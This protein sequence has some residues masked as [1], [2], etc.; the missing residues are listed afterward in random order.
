MLKYSRAESVGLKMSGS[1]E[2]SMNGMFG[3]SMTGIRC[4]FPFVVLNGV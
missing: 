4:P 3:L 1:R 2:M